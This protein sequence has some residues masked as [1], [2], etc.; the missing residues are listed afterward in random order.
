[1]TFVFLSNFFFRQKCPQNGLVGLGTLSSQDYGL[2]L[3]KNYH[4][5]NIFKHSFVLFVEIT[6][7]FTTSQ[8]I[9]KE[10]P[11]KS[12][13]APPNSETKDS[14]GYIQTSFFLVI[15]LDA[16]VIATLVSLLAK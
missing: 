11:R 6:I 9:K 5:H 10:N 13:R 8:I 1:M 7:T 4:H 14:I 15:V 3:F 2:R 12:P 16:I